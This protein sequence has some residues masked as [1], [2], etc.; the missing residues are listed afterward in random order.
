RAPPPVYP[1]SLHGALPILGRDRR[2]RRGVHNAKTF[3]TRFQCGYTPRTRSF[4][5]RSV[6]RNGGKI[7][8]VSRELHAKSSTQSNFETETILDLKS[9]RLNSSHQTLPYA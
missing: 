8:C 5:S 2:A 1:L 4:S 7:S 3:L 6:A 9:T